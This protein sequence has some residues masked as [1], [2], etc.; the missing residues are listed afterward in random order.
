MLLSAGN[1]LTRPKLAAAVTKWRRDWEAVEMERIKMS[2]MSTE[3]S[4]RYQLKKANEEIAR[5]GGHNAE[6]EAMKAAEEKLEAERAKRIEHQAEM[7][8]KRIMKRSL[9]ADGRA[10]ATTSSRRDARGSS[11]RGRQR[12]SQSVSL[13]RIRS[14]MKRGRR[15]KLRRLARLRRVRSV[16]VRAPRLSS[17]R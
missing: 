17:T 3:E 6:E 12:S 2:S 5:L 1:R 9:P 14:G 8:L 13:R 15:S 7:A 4:L 10:G 16:R 11:F